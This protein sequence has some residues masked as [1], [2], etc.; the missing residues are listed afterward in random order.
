VAQEAVA[1]DERVD[2]GH[3]ERKSGSR[4]YRLVGYVGLDCFLA[5]AAV[6]Q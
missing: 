1:T 2:F 5:V 4:H 6:T 3:I